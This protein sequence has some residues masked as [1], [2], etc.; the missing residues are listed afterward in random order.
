MIIINFNSI[1]LSSGSRR[2]QLSNM[3]SNL[4]SFYPSVNSVFDERHYS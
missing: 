3:S 1:K 4:P 2:T